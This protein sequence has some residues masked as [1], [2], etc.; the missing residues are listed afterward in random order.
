MKSED[1][2]I[3]K[4]KNQIEDIIKEMREIK[5]ILHSEILKENKKRD[6]KKI[7]EIEHSLKNVL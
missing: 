5:K 1:E 2:K 3:I 6:L 7:K 4:L